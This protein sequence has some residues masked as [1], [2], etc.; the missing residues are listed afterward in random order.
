MT[1]SQI[2]DTAGLFFA[3]PDAAST[4]A[5]A[6]AVH[7]PVVALPSTRAA[8]PGLQ[9]LQQLQQL[10]PPL[11]PPPMSAPHNSLVA[12]HMLAAHAAACS[13]LPAGL[14]PAGPFASASMS[15]HPAVEM[16]LAPPGA[17]T[18]L[19]PLSLRPSAD[20]ASNGSAAGNAGGGEGE[21]RVGDEVWGAVEAR[22]GVEGGAACAVPLHCVPPACSPCL[23]VSSATVC[24]SLWLTRRREH[25]PCVHAATAAAGA[26]RVAGTRRA[27]T[28]A[29]GARRHCQAGARAAVGG[30]S[31]GAGEDGAR[32]RGAGRQLCALCELA[33]RPTD[34]PQSGR[35]AAALPAICDGHFCQ[36]SATT[37]LCRPSLWQN[38]RRLS[39]RS[40][41]TTLTMQRRGPSSGR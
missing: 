24:L 12:P 22:A 37:L 16:S 1:L 36:T 28:Q 30:G 33:A 7:P 29:Q 13:L 19:C 20:D 41:P 21:Q 23:P 14:S 6:A 10:A 5:A 3:A 11:G 31:G 18:S 38:V 34:S 32:G 25:R 8:L 4:A 9:Q 27:G 15:M 35:A 2:F 26:G 17:H 39:W 40:C